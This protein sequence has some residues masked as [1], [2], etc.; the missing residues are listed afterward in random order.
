MAES[1]RE[2]IQLS[3][4]RSESGTEPLRDW[5]KGLA[6]A[7][8]QAI[9]MDL[10][11]VQWRW[12]V[13]MPLCRPLGAGLFEVRTDLVSGNTA[14]VLICVHAGKLVALH[15]FIKKHRRTPAEDLSLARRRQSM[16]AIAEPGGRLN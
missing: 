3:F 13:G 5:L 12:P 7:D 6:A 10:Q 8:R 11:R 16:L 4:F 2:R 14:R 1:R 9:G 15:G